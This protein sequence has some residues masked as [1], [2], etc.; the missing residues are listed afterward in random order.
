[1]VK[2]SVVIGTI[3]Q[4]LDAIN[5]GAK[6]LNDIIISSDYILFELFIDFYYQRVYRVTDDIFWKFRNEKLYSIFKILKIIL[7][8]YIIISFFLFIFLSYSVY[9][10]KVL[11][12]SLLNFIGILPSKYLYEDEHFY[13][14]IIRIINDYF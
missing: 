14:E 1:M 10:I 13:K 7:I 5:K 9:D 11:F 8:I 2:I 4:E 6:S 3:V 12:Y